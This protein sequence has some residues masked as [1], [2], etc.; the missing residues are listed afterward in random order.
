V[1]TGASTG[2]LK[3]RAAALEDLRGPQFEA[4]LAGSSGARL[5]LSGVL[6]PV[7]ALGD[8]VLRGRA[9]SRTVSLAQPDGRLS[10]ATDRQL[11][12]I[13]LERLDIAV[14]EKA[15]AATAV[16]PPGERPPLLILPLS[17]SSLRSAP[18]R[19]KLLRL[20]AAAQVRLRNL[21]LCEVIGVEPGTP[22]SALREAAGQLQPIFR[23]VLARATPDR[24]VIRDLSG[25]GFGGAT[26]EAADL[27]DAADAAAMLRTV[28]AL[29]KIGPSVMVHAV[30]SVTG[31]SA[32]R[33]A[34]ANWASLDIVPGALESLKLAAETKTAAGETPT[35]V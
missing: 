9:V 11:N 12:A 27:G 26:V 4:G 34:G 10:P 2:R 1:T 28:L 16:T 20:A 32:V 13:D 15:F 14:M 3:A 5:Q 25:C 31:L 8:G 17:W 29:Q 33:A 30:R 19:R 7:I 18:T 23:G 35:A 22:P 6:R 24:K 21:A